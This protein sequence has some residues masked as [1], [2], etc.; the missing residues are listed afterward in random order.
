M[1][2]Q[3][4]Q[5]ARELRRLQTRERILGAAIAEFRASGM[6]GADVGAIV[7]VA[8][9]AHGTFFF[10]FPSKEHVL[11]ELERREETRMAAE[12]T[13][14]LDSPHDLASALTELVRL[15]SSLEQRF[16]PLLF[17]ELLALHFSPTRPTKDEWSDH[18]M[19]VLLVREIERA[20]G[21]GE[22]HPEV[23][24]FYSAAFFL[25]GIYG[26]LTTTANSR[27]RDAMLANLVITARR[28]LEVR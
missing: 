5:S 1:T 14:F 17:K 12:F 22:V 20:R 3:I 28:G 24:A 13:H 8:G 15:I 6:A 10:H 23:D 19:I 21:D 9:V 27:H 26:V 11:L 4:K 16:G 18:P 2:P 7:D 25:L